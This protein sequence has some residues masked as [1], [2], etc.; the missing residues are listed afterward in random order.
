MT[1]YNDHKF[2]F[3]E[4]TLLFW[5]MKREGGCLEDLAPL[6]GTG[7]VFAARGRLQSKPDNGGQCR[8][9]GRGRFE[10]EQRIFAF[11]G[12]ATFGQNYEQRAR[13][14]IG[15]A[16]SE[17]ERSMAQEA[18]ASSLH[19]SL[20][21]THRPDKGSSNCSRSPSE[22]SMTQEAVASSL[23]SLSLDN[24]QRPDKDTAKSSPSSSDPNSPRID[25]NLQVSD[26]VFVSRSL[27]E[28]L[29]AE[30][31][32]VSRGRTESRKARVLTSEREIQAEGTADIKHGNE[33]ADISS[34]SSHSDPGLPLF[35]STPKSAVPLHQPLVPLT[36]DLLHSELEVVGFQ[37]TGTIEDS[38]FEANS[39]EATVGSMGVLDNLDQF[40][41]EVLEENQKQ[42]VREN[43]RGPRRRIFGRFASSEEETTEF[44]SGIL[45][46]TAQSRFVQTEPLEEDVLGGKSEEGTW[47]SRIT[48]SYQD[49]GDSEEESWVAG[50][51]AGESDEGSRESPSSRAQRLQEGIERGAVAARKKKVKVASRVSK[52]QRAGLQFPVSR[53]RRHLKSSA[54]D[55]RLADNAAVYLT[56]VCEYMVTEMLEISGDVAKVGHRKRIRPSD[57]RTAIRNDDELFS[58]LNNV[59]IPLEQ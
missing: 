38:V 40:S 13:M 23:H 20:D 1:T 30:S 36:Q 8:Y 48:V 56:A 49:T 28:Y 24:S 52:S 7:R 59:I 46:E 55:L 42:E 11:R 57:I 31:H 4:R 2:S 33:L 43:E 29:T 18:F 15:M 41:H 19:S 45:A 51:E 50:T 14:E 26:S 54:A 37:S 5:K 34:I 9:H 53:I 58:L 35:F 10:D 39:K 21:N 47:D 17:V 3:R 6:P 12:T 44:T 27:E 22:P 25:P 32:Q 16:W